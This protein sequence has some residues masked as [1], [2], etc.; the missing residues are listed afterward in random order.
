MTAFFEPDGPDRFRATEFTRGPW[1][2][3]AQH[4]GPPAALLGRAMQRCNPR[5]DMQIVRVTLDILRPIPIT[6]LEVSAQVVR[7]GRRVELLSAELR[8][9][10]ETVM[11]A[12]GWRIRTEDVGVQ[13]GLDAP[14]PA[15]P[16]TVEPE[17]SFPWADGP[18]YSTAMEWRAV[19]GMFFEPGPAAVWLRMR[20]PLV[21]G[22]EPTPLTRVLAAAD[23]GSGVSS[24][25]PLDQYLFINTDLTV[26]LHRLPAGEWVCLDAAT[27]IEPHGIGM[28]ESRI[29]DEQGPIG[30]GVQNLFV[31]RR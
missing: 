7:P 14:L 17:R 30:R 13:V 12:T 4:G 3:G 6:L 11:R 1:D 16:D 23:S 9:A 27:V 19:R 15:L 21:E 24:A 22:E 2:P 29:F 10:G 31:A 28:A 25:L 20:V 5:E 18:S 8:A 26:S